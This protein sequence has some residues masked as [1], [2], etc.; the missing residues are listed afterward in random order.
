MA[1][2]RGRTTVLGVLLAAGALGACSSDDT[3]DSGSIP[4]TAASVTSTTMA[5]TTTATPT[6][7]SPPTTTT[8]PPS[9]SSTS[10]TAATTTT[11]I[12]PG[13]ELVISNTG[14]GTANFGAD[15]NAVVHYVTAIIGPPTADSGAVDPAN[16]GVCPGTTVR[17]VTWNDLVAYFGDESADFGGREHFI[18]FTLGPP[19][20]G[21]IRPA[22]M[23]TDANIGIGTGYPEMI[24]TYPQAPVSEPTPSGAFDFQVDSGVVVRT[25]GID[26]DSV[27]IS[28]RGGNGCRPVSE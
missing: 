5:A 4:T 9:T 6:T 19:L 16:F 11:T 14:I 28:I 1:F 8:T 3:I 24:A 13:V 26:V 20:S 25:N 2:L 15:S 12:P 18:G 7:T 27:V 10:T 21:T 23:A 22:G 17:A